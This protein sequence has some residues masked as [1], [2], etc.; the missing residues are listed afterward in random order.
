[1]ERNM[2]FVQSGSLTT[3]ELIQHADLAL[4]QGKSLPIEW[5]KELV[6]RL[7][8]EV[9]EHG[10]TPYRDPRQLPLF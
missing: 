2:S 6:R 8:R 5:Q 1:M 9:N 4:L 10:Y 7:D 3:K